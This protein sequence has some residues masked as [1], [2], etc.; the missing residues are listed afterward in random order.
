MLTLTRHNLY[1]EQKFYKKW[2]NWGNQST[3]H[4][5]QFKL[6]AQVRRERTLKIQPCGARPW[7]SPAEI[8]SL[9]C[10]RLRDFAG[11]EK[12]FPPLF[13]KQT[14]YCRVI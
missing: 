13:T 10:R 1:D 2:N 7:R 5:K 11:D 12:Q 9:L 8:T 4:S 14:V 6:N 3:R